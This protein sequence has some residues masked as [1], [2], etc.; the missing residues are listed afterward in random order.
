MNLWLATKADENIIS[1]LSEWIINTQPQKE[2]PEYKSWQA[3]SMS[4]S[5]LERQFKQKT[6]SISPESATQMGSIPP[7]GTYKGARG[8]TLAEED[9]KDEQ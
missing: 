5:V 3:A 6:P 2:D 9:K 7:G 4:V 1:E 8:A